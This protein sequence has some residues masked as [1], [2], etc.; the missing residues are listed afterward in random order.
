M[1]RYPNAVPVTA[2][3]LV[4]GAADD[5]SRADGEV[6]AVARTYQTDAEFFPSMGHMMMLEPGWQAVAER[7]EGWLGGQGL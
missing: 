2:P 6:S 5:G 4:L 3:L 1:V 7:M